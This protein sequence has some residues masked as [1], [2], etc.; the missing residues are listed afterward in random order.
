MA[1]AIMLQQGAFA[2]LPDLTAFASTGVYF[3]YRG[4]TV[5]Y[6][7]KAVDVRRRIANH[8]ADGVKS[9]DGVSFIPCRR[10]DLTRIETKYIALLC[11]EYNACGVARDA[12]LKPDFV[13]MPVEQPLVADVRPRTVTR[14][15]RALAMR[16]R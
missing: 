4:P 2:H 1:Q 12:R 10:N 9:F 6:V 8:I 3:L 11:P 14:H 16:A 5:V 7:G 13:P 15:E